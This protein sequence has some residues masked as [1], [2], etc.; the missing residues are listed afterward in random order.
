MTYTKTPLREAR[1]KRKR[2]LMAVTDYLVPDVEDLSAVEGL[3]DNLW[4]VHFCDEFNNVRDL[5][6][7]QMDAA[8]PRIRSLILSLL[9]Q[10]VL[11]TDPALKVPGC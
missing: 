9:L 10:D 11:Q 3:E 6:L 4:F 8:F 7:A 2:M 5:P 1:L